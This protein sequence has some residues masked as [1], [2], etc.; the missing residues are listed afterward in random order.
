MMVGEPTG[1]DPLLRR[2][3]PRPR[4]GG[5]IELVVADD[6]QV[7]AEVRTAVPFRLVDDAGGRA[8][9]ARHFDKDGGYLHVYWGR[10]VGERGEG[11]RFPN[12]EAIVDVGVAGDYAGRILNLGDPVERGLAGRLLAQ[13]TV[14]F[15]W[16]HEGLEHTHLVTEQMR[17]YW[18]EALQL[19]EGMS[20]E[21]F[22]EEIAERPWYGRKGGRPR[23]YRPRNVKAPKVAVPFFAP[24]SGQL[25]R[26]GSPQVAGIQL[27]AG[28][29][30]P[31]DH[32]GVSAFWASDDNV[33]LAL[34]SRL[35]AAFAQ[36]GLWPL[37]WTWTDEPPDNYLPGHGDVRKIA[38]HDMEK[39]RA[40]AYAEFDP[41]AEETEPFDHWP[42]SPPAT[43]TAPQLDPFD[44]FE[45]LHTP[46]LRDCCRQLL[47]IPCNRPADA[48]TA[49]DWS[50][51]LFDSHQVGAILRSFEERFGAVPVALHLIDVVCLAVARAPRT[52]QDA[53][54]LAAE[55]TVL[56]PGDPASIAAKTAA[57][58][59]QPP[60]PLV[61]PERVLTPRRW[62]LILES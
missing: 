35:A 7:V 17:G 18:T 8:P 22:A 33:D 36:T 32:D 61:A 54:L 13:E 2:P 51:Q 15:V 25:P 24:A 11:W 55:L 12:I 49:L 31:E 10:A 28:R 16:I 38:R 56:A 39:I 5:T 9:L 50:S 40:Y 19:T 23:L 53:Q 58:L 48:L 57:L 60:D 62:D 42:P 47:L 4:P 1:G 43:S 45:V 20:A 52:R 14:R 29:R 21:Q 34:A 44:P 59:G 26:D 41:S 30:L 3:A 46:P 27:P 6:R 37:I